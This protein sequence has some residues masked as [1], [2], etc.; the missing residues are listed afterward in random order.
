MHA[1]VLT[2]DVVVN[3][4]REA[5]CEWSIVYINQR[6]R[7]HTN[8]RRYESKFSCFARSPALLI[9]EYFIRIIVRFAWIKT[10]Q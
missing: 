5:K 4:G 7:K 8:F 10:N 9:I 3:G 6:T 2:M 1:S